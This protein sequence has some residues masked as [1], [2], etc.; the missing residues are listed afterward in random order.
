[1]RRC[2]RWPVEDS[3]LAEVLLPALGESVTEGIVTKWFK[4]VGDQVARDEPLFEISTDKVDSEVPSPTAGVL[5]AIHASEG[6]TVAVGAAVATIGDATGAAQPAPAADPA[7]ATA[8]PAAPESAPAAPTVAPPPTAPAPAAAPAPAPEPVAATGKAVTASPMVRKLLEQA[9]RPESSI[10]PSGPGG[11]IT[12]VDAEAALRAPRKRAPLR[13]TGP[14]ALEDVPQGSLRSFVSM[15]IDLDNVALALK[16]PKVASLATEGIEVTASMVVARATAE[17]LVE[18]PVLNSTIEG[19]LAVPQAEVNLGMTVDLEGNLLAP[20]VPSAQDLNLRGLARRFGEVLGRAR[21][22]SL[23][24]SDLMGGTFSMSP[25][26]SPEVLVAIPPLLGSQ[27]AVLSLGGVA[28]RPVALSD[29]H[30][31][32][33][34][35]RTNAVVGL[36]YDT[37]VVDATTATAFLVRLADVLTERDW[38]AE[39]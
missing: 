36:A 14:V 27:V 33:L 4:A 34:A 25:A 11:R 15:E 16:S 17:V 1:M 10:S 3:T 37:R 30:G 31:D 32:S 29:E 7:P 2:W 6:D 28:K 39:L 38:V 5:T 35:I 23:D 21:S 8:P 13:P 9:G 22:G 12:R 19:D 18:F 24:I 20:V 26:N